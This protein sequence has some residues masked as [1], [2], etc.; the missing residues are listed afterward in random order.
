MLKKVLLAVLT[1]FISVSSDSEGAGS[2]EIDRPSV[3]TSVEAAASI[4]MQA[5][6]PADP[7]RKTVETQEKETDESLKISMSFAGD[8]TLGTD[9]SF[10]YKASF[11]YVLARN[12]YDY[13]YFFGGVREVFQ[14]D[15][16]SMVNLETTLTDAGKPAKKE[17]RFKGEPAYAE[18]LQTASVEVVNIA[19]NHTM[20][21]LQE[22]FDDTLAAL[23]K[24]GVEYSGWEYAPRMDV[25]GVK[26]AFIGYT[27]WD[28][29]VRGKLKESLKQAREEAQ[30]VI[31]SLHWG[32]ERVYTP[33]GG[34]ISLAHFCIDNGADAV[35]G[36]HPHVLQ[37]VECYK[38]RYIAYSLGN[39]CFGGNRNPSDKDSMIFRNVF[40]LRQGKLVKAEAEILPCSISSS[41][42]I[43]DY[44]P[45]LLHGSEKD[46]VLAKI[47][48]TG[49]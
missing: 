13:A 5:P 28:A 16:L 32:R 14:S 7:G 27:A 40:E 22:G 3:D 4:S 39:F 1:L 45:V 24:A 43:N 42:N 49:W 48:K 10:P 23:E 8:C 20:D 35:I 2:V 11:P 29:D 12:N 31:V 36:H 17:F 33:D 38:K 21:Y 47:K 34:Q 30:I 18:I 26:V 25:K 19:N 6:G 37:E 41:P 15:D 44:R 9:A 46:R